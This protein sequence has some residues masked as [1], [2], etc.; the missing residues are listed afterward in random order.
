VV[1]TVLCFLSYQPLFFFFFLSVDFD[2]SITSTEHFYLK[3]IYLLIHSCVY[4]VCVYVYIQVGS[5]PTLPS[6]DITALPHHLQHKKP[7]KACY[8][9][10]GTS[11]KSLY[12]NEIVDDPYNPSTEGNA[13]EA[14]FLQV[15]DQPGQQS[16]TMFKDKVEV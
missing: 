9:W 16:E 1:G 2:S 3:H 11:C 13:A 10:V 12:R 14:E 15:P 8:I 5:C 7:L 6:K 4:D